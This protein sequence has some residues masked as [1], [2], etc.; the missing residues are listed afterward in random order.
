MALNLKSPTSRA[1]TEKHG[2]RHLL[3]AEDTL[4]RWMTAYFAKIGALG[5]AVWLWRPTAASLSTRQSRYTDEQLNC[6]KR[7]YMK[8]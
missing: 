5:L 8:R 7:M 6:H 4:E 1:Q 2:L 3:P